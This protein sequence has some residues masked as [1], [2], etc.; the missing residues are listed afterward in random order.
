MKV[1]NKSGNINGNEPSTVTDAVY[2]D[3]HRIP[4]QAHGDADG[5]ETVQAF[6]CAPGCPVAGLDAQS[7]T[8]TSG[9]NLSRSQH[10]TSS[11]TL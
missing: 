5:T 11:G 9:A 10:L 6:T 4:W 2:A 8:L 7:G 3:R 1:R